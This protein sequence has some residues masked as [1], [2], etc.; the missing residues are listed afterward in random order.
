MTRTPKSRIPAKFFATL[1]TTGFVLLLIAANVSKARAQSVDAPP[2]IAPD[3]VSYSPG[4]TMVL[5]GAN[6]LPGEAVTVVSVRRLG[7]R[8][9]NAR[10]RRGWLGLVH[11]Q[12]ALR[13][14]NLPRQRRRSPHADERTG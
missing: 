6:W 12:R 11:G 7:E 4:E 1:A 2:T 10:G 9:R 3:K 5:T 14:T 13:P 8:R